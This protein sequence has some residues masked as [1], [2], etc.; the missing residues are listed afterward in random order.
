MRRSPVRLPSVASYHL[1][2]KAVDEK[3]LGNRA[4]GAKEYPQAVTH[5]SKCI[6]LDPECAFAPFSLTK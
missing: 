5:F 1:Q 3:G 6:E 2:A 4:F